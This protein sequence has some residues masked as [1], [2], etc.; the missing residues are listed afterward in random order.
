[1]KLPTTIAAALIALG[2]TAEADTRI[3]ANCFFPSQH[4]VCRDILK[5][6]GDQVEEVTEGRVRVNVPAKSM[7]PPAEQLASVRGGVFDAALQ[8]NGLI[9]GESL[10]LEVSLLPFVNGS[11]ALANSL[12]FWR[13]YERYVATQDPLDGV[14]V[15]GVMSAGGVD[16]YSLTDQ[17]IETLEDIRN[18]KMWALPG[19]PAAVVK[20]TG[21]ATVSG[22]AVQMTEM[23]Q[24]GVVDGFVGIAPSNVTALSL[25][26]YVELMTQTEAKLFA[27]T[28][29]FV[30]SEEKWAEIDPADQEAIMAI[31]G[32][33]FAELGGG[34]YA[35]ADG[36]AFAELAEKAEII[37]ADPAFE[38][39]LNAI[40]APFRQSWIEAASAKRIDAQAALDFY[41]STVLELTAD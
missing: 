21:S 9:P 6:W 2:G 41:I 20:D 40:A 17:P 5:P 16:F 36:A 23:I 33:A 37:Q 24:R 11:D 3:V 34:A 29:T 15:L 28:F 25:M 27:S 19:L 13:T 8:F 38:A 39:E 12:A 4:F 31:S 26:A 30:I 1:M 35:K 7:A 22:P 14:Q 18:R 32:E 10:G